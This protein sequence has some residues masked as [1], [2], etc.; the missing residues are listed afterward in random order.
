MSKKIYRQAHK[1]LSNLLKIIFLVGCLLSISF[2]SWAISAEKTSQ[3]PNQNSSQISL[4]EEV[5][6]T[7]K[8]KKS[9]SYSEFSE[10]IAKVENYLNS[11]QNLSAKFTQQSAS[12]S[13]EGKFYLVRNQ[14]SAGKMRVEY[15]K[16][17]KIRI[18]VNGAVLSYIDVELEEISRLSTNSTP[19]SLLTRP[20]I[21]FTAKDV[22]ITDISKNDDL[23]KISLMKK[24]RKE[25]GEFSL[26]FKLNPIEFVKMEVKND[27]N[28]IV[29]VTL[30]DVDL[31]TK[32]S[33]QVFF[34]KSQE[35]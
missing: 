15:L 2:E 26:F 35:E 12:G 20:Q 28:Q 11:I 32:I 29:A 6:K 25:A 16:K 10:D 30:R 13:V 3:T 9:V 24:N 27:L 8:P 34:V 14:N 17:P 18:I 7:K 22:E 23:L 5:S 21:S 4:A 1:K 19:A 33:D 31:E